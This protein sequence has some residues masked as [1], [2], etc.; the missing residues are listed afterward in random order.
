MN[1][2]QTYNFLKKDKTPLSGVGIEIKKLFRGI[3]YDLLFN[4]F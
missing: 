2:V 1:R 3:R 4:I